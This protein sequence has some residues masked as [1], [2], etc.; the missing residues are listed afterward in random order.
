MAEIKQTAESV[1][2]GKEILAML[3]KVE[4]RLEALEKALFGV[5]HQP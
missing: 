2:A 3:A 4:Q 1:S 5:G